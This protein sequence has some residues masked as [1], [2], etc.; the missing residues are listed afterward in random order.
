MRYTLHLIKHQ[1]S[2][3][4]WT[5]AN[6][7]ENNTPLPVE[8]IQKSQFIC[9][10]RTEKNSEVEWTMPCWD[11]IVKALKWFLMRKYETCRP[12]FNGHQ[13]LINC[14]AWTDVGWWE[15]LQHQ[16][17]KRKKRYIY[18]YTYVANRKILLSSTFGWW[19][20]CSTSLSHHFVVGVAKAD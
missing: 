13:C 20:C 6:N 11:L 14:V 8:T 19:I 3:K 2:Q 17:P 7:M 9:T 10:L 1:I 15:R 12:N 16:T 5:W 18:I 4:I